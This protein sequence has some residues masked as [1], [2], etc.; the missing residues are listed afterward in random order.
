MTC[1]LQLGEVGA[2]AEVRAAAAEGDVRVVRRRARDV[3]AERVGEHLLVEVGRHVP[4]DDLVAGP[5]RL[6]RAA[7]RRGSPCAGSAAPATTSA[8][9]SSPALPDELGSS[10]RR[11]HCSR[12]SISASMPCAIAWRVVSLPATTSSQ[13][14]RVELALGQ[15]PAVDLGVDELAT[16]GRPAAAAAARRRLVAVLEELERGRA[17][18]RQQPV[19][20]RSRRVGRARSASSGSVLPIM[21]S[22]QSISRSSS[23]WGTPRMRPS[24]RIGSCSRSPRRSRTRPGA[25]RRRGSPR[26]ARA[27]APRRPPPP[28]GVKRGPTSPRRRVCSGGSVSSIDLRASML[29]RVEVLE[30]RALSPTRTSSCP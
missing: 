20:R 25:A 12:C 16:R 26:S 19:A 1:D 21:R 10:R 28:A 8:G 7:R 18:E 4:D 23:A 27:A 30:V 24:T 13:E 2:E 5:D 22:P 9:S 6:R 3:E 14:H 29:L 17:A 15:P 11:R